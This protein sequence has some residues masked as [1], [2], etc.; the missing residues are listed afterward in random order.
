LIGADVLKQQSHSLDMNCLAYS[1]NGQ[2]VVTG[3]DDGKVKVWN[4]SNGFCFVTFTEHT[5]PVTALTFSASSQA[6]FSASLDGTVR[7]FDLIRYRNFRTLTP[8]VSA[9]FSSVA[10]DP[11]GEIVCA[12]TLDTFAIFVWSVQTGRLLD[13]LRGHQ[14]PISGLAFNPLQ[15]TLASVSWDKTCRVWQVFEGRTS[16]ES[17][18]HQTDVLAV[19]IRP[20]GKEL[21]TSSLDGQLLFWDA[22]E[23]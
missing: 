22:A 18:K 1:Q 19:A 16:I 23:G 6:V 14:G 5:A 11:S 13:I 12:G 20:D 9:Q 15:P 3:G 8:N 2:L 21:C 17:F 4:V 10:V 7:A